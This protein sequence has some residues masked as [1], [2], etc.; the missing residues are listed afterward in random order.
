[1]KNFPVRNR[2]G[3]GGRREGGTQDGDGA[4]KDL[5]VAD[6]HGFQWIKENAFK[7]TSGSERIVIR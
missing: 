7:G 4:E 1:L 2:R 5:V 3:V 6:F